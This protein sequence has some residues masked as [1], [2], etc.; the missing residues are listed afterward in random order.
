MLTIIHQG[1]FTD[2]RIEIWLRT[3]HL[4]N[5]KHTG[6]GD[7]YLPTSKYQNHGQLELFLGMR[8]LRYLYDICIVSH[9]CLVNIYK[10]W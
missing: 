7:F 1:C 8:L 6:N 2:N 4:S 5:P 10:K 3:C 9:I